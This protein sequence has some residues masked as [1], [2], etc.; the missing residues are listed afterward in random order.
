M[1]DLMLLES[2]AA[3]GKSA[4]LFFVFLTYLCLFLRDVSGY[5]FDN[6]SLVVMGGYGWVVV[7]Y[8]MKF[9]IDKITVSFLLV[10]I[11]IGATSYIHPNSLHVFKYFILFFFVVGSYLFF[12][13]IFQ[14]DRLYQKF[15]EYFVFFQSFVALV[16]VVDYLLFNYGVISLVRDYTVSNQVDSFYNN[17]NPFGVMSVF[18]FIV[19][20]DGEKFSR[21][22]LFFLGPV[23]LAGVFSSGSNMS[24]LLVFSWLFLR[25]F[26]LF[27]VIVCYAAV[28][29]FLQAI[30][31]DFSLV[32]NKR[33][34]IWSKAY[35]MWI[36]F[37]VLGMGFS[38]FQL[39]NENLDIYTNINSTH[40][41][42]SMLAWAIFELGLLGGV[43]FG[44]FVC[45]VF[46][47]SQ[48]GSSHTQVLLIIILLSQITEFFLDHEEVFIMF[49]IATV[50]R[51]SAVN[52][53][54]KE[55]YYEK[56]TI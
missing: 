45:F 38:N 32:L 20:A 18:A 51:I 10:V 15:N 53:Q 22:T 11:Y 16:G 40:G 4:L 1:G 56:N 14:S 37:P 44:L 42:H 27:K 3:Y 21:K 36:D 50:A 31:F 2:K 35:S 7:L 54:K 5:K 19:L 24:L 48:K 29:V 39:L 33:M 52:S 46:F 9:P 6:L 43:L 17:P 28:L 47:A 12:K 49:F 55:S 23:L 8:R 26:G 34:D 25:S 13:K 30:A 41:L